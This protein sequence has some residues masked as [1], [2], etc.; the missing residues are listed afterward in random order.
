MQ[1]QDFRSDLGNYQQ[2]GGDNR[3]KRGY[4]EVQPLPFDSTIQTKAITTVELCYSINKLFN[5]ICQ[6]YDGSII[7]MNQFG[8]LELVLYF[9][10]KGEPT[11]SSKFK[12][13]INTSVVKKTD[14]ALDRLKRVSTRNFSRTFELTDDTKD[15]LEEFMNI[16]PNQKVNW[17][18]R[19]NVTEVSQQTS[20][21]NAANKISVKVTGLDLQKIL[22]K[23]YGSKIN[24]NKV[25]YQ[26]TVV[27]PIGQMVGSYAN[28]LMTLSR[29]D[30]SKLEELCTSAGMMPVHNSIPMVTGLGK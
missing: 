2:K 5:S 21:S 1:Q 3:P 14:S 30:C 23:I 29:L 10:D 13:L 22:R 17:A 12:N 27:T 19:N 4:L 18:N 11:D 15:L 7:V 6:D 26:L 9:S 25:D 24:G 8:N 28:Y 20:Y 16:R